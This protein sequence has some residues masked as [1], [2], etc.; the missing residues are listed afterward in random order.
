[1]AIIDAVSRV[2]QLGNADSDSNESRIY[3]PAIKQTEVVNC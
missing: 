2:T 3:V 1:M